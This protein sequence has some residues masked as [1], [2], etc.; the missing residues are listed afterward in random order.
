MDKIY[1]IINQ[2]NEYYYYWDKKFHK[3]IIR[4]SLY[5][6]LISAQQELEYLNSKNNTNCKIVEMEFYQKQ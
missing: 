3:E 6:S 5:A 1:A 4:D 2:K